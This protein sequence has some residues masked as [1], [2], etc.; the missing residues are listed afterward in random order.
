MNLQNLSESNFLDG[1]V[2]LTATTGTPFFEKLLK[3]YHKKSGEAV[4]C[5]N[6]AL[7]LG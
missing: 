6:L 3:V 2:N 5:F 7:K 1:G 4:F